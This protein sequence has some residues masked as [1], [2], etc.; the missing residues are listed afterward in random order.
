VAVSVK[1]GHHQKGFSFDAMCYIIDAGAAMRAQGDTMTNDHEKQKNAKTYEYFV[2]Q[3]HYET[4]QPA[5][6]GAQIKA[7]I[8]N[9]QPG[10]GLS[11]E[12]HGHDPDRL[13]G[14]DELVQLDTGHGPARF[15]LVPP[16]TFG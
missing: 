9:L 16:A 14:D 3:D 2:N 4:D 11:L 7:R 13:I 12:G 10:T 15:T 1:R 8:P 5:L 6:T